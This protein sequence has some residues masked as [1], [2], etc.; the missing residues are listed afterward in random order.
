MKKAWEKP[1]LLVLVRG[2]PEEV[3]ITTCKYVAPGL[4]GPTMAY[5]GCWQVCGSQNRIGMFAS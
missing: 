1:R 5:D 4:S 2:R 3:L